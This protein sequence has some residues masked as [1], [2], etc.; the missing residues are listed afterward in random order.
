MKRAELRGCVCI[1]RDK[2]TSRDEP[3]ENPLK[4]ACFMTTF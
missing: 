1:H 4:Q 3:L 2:P